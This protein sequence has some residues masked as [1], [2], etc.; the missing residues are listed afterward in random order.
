MKKEYKTM[1]KRK[2]REQKKTRPWTKE[3]GIEDKTMV[4]RNGN[5]RQ[6]D[7]GQ[8]KRE[9]KTTRQLSKQKGIEDN[10]TMNKRKGNKNNKRMIKRKE[11]RRLQDHGQKK[12]E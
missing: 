1:G 6:Q 12:R 7:H 4:K 11:N 9:Q 10:K 8:K 3:K 5:R 2:E